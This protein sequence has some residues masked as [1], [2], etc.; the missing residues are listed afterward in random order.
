MHTYCPIHPQGGDECDNSGYE[1]DRYKNLLKT[2]IILK[3]N[4]AF[5]F[6]AY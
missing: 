6:T 5:H 2:H 4:G 1:W 3:L